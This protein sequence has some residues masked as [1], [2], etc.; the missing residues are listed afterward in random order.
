MKENSEDFFCFLA[1]GHAVDR[2][3]CDI[4]HGFVGVLS[5]ER[6]L[7]SDKSS[8]GS[9]L[10]A[11]IDDRDIVGFVNTSPFVC[12]KSPDDMLTLVLNARASYSTGYVAITTFTWHE[13]EEEQGE[14]V[15]IR[16]IGLK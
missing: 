8:V 13:A 2:G 3:D 10:K 1:R 6:G 9:A 12:N 4:S 5:A 16:T 15:E 14:G 11:S 7:I